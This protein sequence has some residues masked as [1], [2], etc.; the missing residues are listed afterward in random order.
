MDL[1]S[2]RN[3]VDGV[4]VSHTRLVRCFGL[5]FAASCAMGRGK[6]EELAAWVRPPSSEMRL[7]C[8]CRSKCEL[9]AKRA[10]PV[11]FMPGCKA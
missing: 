4:L 8:L 2:V 10:A 7:R 3:R 6:E 11:V 9:Y 1:G 5:V